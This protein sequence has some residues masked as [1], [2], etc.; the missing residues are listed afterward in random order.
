MPDTT[1]RDWRVGFIG[2]GGMGLP[3]AGRLLHHGANLTVYNRTASRCD[4]LVERGATAVPT[5]AEVARRSDVVIGMVFDGAALHEVTLGEN[6]VLA[7]A[8]TGMIFVD[9]S[10]VSPLES[11]RVA[12]AMGAAGVGF[13]R[14]PVTGTTPHAQAG[15]LGVLASGQREHFDAVL[16]MLGAMSASQRYVG[17]AEEA[18]VLKLAIN[19]MLATIL[20]ALAEAIVLGEK[21]GLGIGTILDVIAESPVG[22]PVVK[23]RS[24]GIANRSFVPG[25]TPGLL[26][27]D[28]ILALGA[29]H[30]AGATMPVTAVTCQLLQQMQGIGLGDRDVG[31]LVLLLEQLSGL[32]A[33][34]G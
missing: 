22:A 17:A 19:T 31:G 30:A 28:L 18:R 2:L 21:H 1:L 29:A 15:T 14:A 16:P 24:A 34:Q 3:M 11:V 13:L 6:G 7:G 8:H 25:G 5:P 26:M 4:T 33:P 32:P 23:Y 27:K 12:E 20:A 9:M 10:T